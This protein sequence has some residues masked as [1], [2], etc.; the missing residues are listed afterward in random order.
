MQTRAVAGQ[1]LY[2]V[3]LRFPP[4]RGEAEAEIKLGTASQKVKIPAGAGVCKAI[5]LKPVPGPVRVDTILTG[6]GVVRGAHYADI[7]WR[8]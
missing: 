5:G 4:F 8:P 3:E 7:L 2:D 6:D 1:G